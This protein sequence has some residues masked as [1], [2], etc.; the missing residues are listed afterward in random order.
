[1]GD[2][3]HRDDIP[4]TNAYLN[5]L[6][7]NI[8][9][10]CSTAILNTSNATFDTANKMD[11]LLQL[12][13]TI[14]GSNITKSEISMIN[15]KSKGILELTLIALVSAEEATKKCI[16][17]NI[18]NVK[19]AV[20]MTKLM[21]QHMNEVFIYINNIY[22]DISRKKI[23]QNITVIEKMD[24]MLSYIWKYNALVAYKRWYNL[25]PAGRKHPMREGGRH[26]RTHRKRTHRR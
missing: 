6:D 7:G 14:K 21:W 3:R 9:T 22:N 19:A 23:N 8:K 1:M 24:T 17:N 26:R 10:S 15:S 2:R 25:T 11:D 16:T 5:A 13:R 20:E 4:N 18:D 12:L